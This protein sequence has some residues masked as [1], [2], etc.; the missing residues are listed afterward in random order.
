MN[1]GL[2]KKG[3][4]KAFFCFIFLLIVAM[5]LECQLRYPDTIVLFEGETLP[6]SG[7]SAYYMDIPAG[8]GGV[9]TENGELWA[10]SYSQ[11]M[12]ASE[13]G[14]YDV[15]LKLFGLIPVRTVTVDV[16]PQ[17][18]L[19]ACGDSVGIKIFT[20]GLLCVGTQTVRSENGTM[21]DLSKSAD[22]RSGDI[23]LKA[24]DVELKDT[25][26][27]E[28][29]VQNCN[30][31]AISFTVLREGRE[32]IKELT[33]I[34]TKEGYKMGFWLR[35]STAG[36]GTLTFYD[37]QTLRFGALGHPIADRDTGALMQVSDGELVEASVL[38]VQKGSKGEPGELKGIFKTNAPALGTVTENT[39]KGVFGTLTKPL[40]AEH[41]YPVA[42]RNQVK[43]GKAKILSNVSEEEIET[44]DI[45]IQKSMG[46]FGTGAK[47]MIIHI[48]DPKLLEK[49]GGIVQGMSGSPIV[50]NGKLVGAVTHVFV[51]DPTRGYG[52]FIENMLAESE[53]IK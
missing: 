51:N 16:R 14:D 23:F 42:S 17:T 4:V 46:Y 2:T 8:V 34:K 37:P 29:I 44:F 7:K 6:L 18:E 32:L 35:D 25:E 36:I 43:E 33:P 19:V 49:T 53:K 1:Q 26:Q 50:Q 9:L 21:Q 47:D 27:M 12:Q 39:D 38:S 24:G 52:I 5:T 13:T 30:G 45:E 20:E 40:N 31:K 22:I 28:K 48:T 15:T 41:I 10:D 11:H 3:R